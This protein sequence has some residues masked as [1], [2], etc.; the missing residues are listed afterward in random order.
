METPPKDK[1]IVDAA[2]E[3]GKTILSVVPAAGGPLVALF[4]TIFTAPLN[5]RRQAWLEE[6]A[7]VISDIQDKLSDITPEKLAANEM[8]ITAALQAS[9]IAIRNHKKEKIDA[10]KNALF[11]SVQPKAPSEDI[12]LIFLKL[13]DDLTPW[14]LRLL[15][16]L[17]DPAKWMV[18]NGINNPG[19][20]TGGV[21]T[22]IEQCFPELR[23]NRD[24][25]DQLARD[26]QADG[27][28]GQGNFLNLTMSGGSMLES[29]TS[30][31]GKQFIEFISK[32]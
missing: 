8:F 30:P 2:H 19:W 5:K 13:I 12:Q 16:M 17:N 22:V 7:S 20:G 9:Q 21:S 24:F 32:T 4:E 3:I 23:G 27:L 14:H 25:Y 6:L 28:L 1:S 11:N 15:S 29:R 18:Q 31:I 26:L 10:L